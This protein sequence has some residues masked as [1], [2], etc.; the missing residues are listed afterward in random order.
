MKPAGPV[1]CPACGSADTAIAEEWPRT[2]RYR[3]MACWHCGLLFAHPQPAPELLAAY[4]S[5]SG[6]WRETRDTSG[7]QTKGKGR[8][9]R[10]VVALF[11]EQLPPGSR[12]VLDFGC[13]T[14][15][16]LNTLQDA[17]WET[18]GIEPSSDAAFVRHH[19]LDEIPADG[20]FDLVV[21]YHV[22]EHLPRPLD[23]L[24]QL[25]AAVRMGGICFVSVPRLDTVLTHRDPR[26]CLSAP[27]HLVSFTEACLV[28][29]LARAGFEMVA[30]LHHLD[31]LFTKGRPL[32]M[33]LLARR[34]EL[35]APGPDPA[36]ALRS[37]L[38]AAPALFTSSS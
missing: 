17:G 30:A 22:L 11:E 37:V 6:H 16:W 8:A 2:G 7:A 34:V 28:G 10:A 21:A 1:E 18:Y 20:S 23:T 25:A 3:A 15:P 19:R 24:R 4:Y 14:G 35:A 27:H 9:G 38:S 13:G 33:R 12:R 5:P 32:R 36:P 29:L 26:Y 31:D